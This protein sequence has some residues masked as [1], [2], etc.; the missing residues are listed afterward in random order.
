MIAHH[1][2]LLVAQ[3]GGYLGL[4]GFAAAILARWYAIGRRVRR[5]GSAPVESSVDPIAGTGTA[6]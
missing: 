6:R 2:V 3:A 4:S 1:E 5:S